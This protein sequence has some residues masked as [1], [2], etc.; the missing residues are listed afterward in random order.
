MFYSQVILAK[1]GPL[2]KVWLAA[3]WGDK[4]LARPQIFAT[5]IAQSVDTIVHPTAPLALRMSGY[6]LLGV[7]RIYSRKVKYV[8]NDCTEA[9]WKLQMAFRSGGSGAAKELLEEAQLGAAVHGAHTVEY[10]ELP[11]VQGFCLPL[12][13]QNEWI[14]DDQDDEPGHEGHAGRDTDDQALL[15][16]PSASTPSGHGRPSSLSMSDS[17][18]A[19][20]QEEAWV[21]FDPDQ[22]DPDVPLDDSRVSEVE[23]VRAAG[24]S[25]SIDELNVSHA[26][27]TDAAAALKQQQ[28]QQ[29]QD[30]HEDSMDLPMLDNDDESAPGLADLP[31]QDT[32]LQLSTVS[33][34]PNRLSISALEDDESHATAEQPK[35]TS[36]PPKHARRKRRKVLIDNQNTELSNAHIKL[37]L[38]DTSDICQRQVHPA[39]QPREEGTAPPALTS[40][41]Q[42]PLSLTRPFLAPLHS[43]L[44]EL[45]QGAWYLALGQPPS[46]ERDT[47]LPATEQ[48]RQAPTGA[49]DDEDDASISRLSQSSPAP[50][51]VR[52]DDEESLPPVLLEREED[53]EDFPGVQLQDEE[54]SLQGASM[55]MDDE[56]QVSL[57]LDDDD[58]D[59]NDASVD[60]LAN[61][62]AY[63]L[64]PRLQQRL[65][66]IRENEDDATD[67]DNDDK[68][69]SLDWQELVPTQTSRHKAAMCFMECLQLQT[70]DFVHLEQETPYG[71]IRLMAGPKLNEEPP[72]ANWA[73]VAAQEG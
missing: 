1:K 3:H 48:V 72:R 31:E 36:P 71:A 66:P 2:A 9:M 51:V 53:D 23:M 34:Q 58:D 61:R 56:D 8:L 57:P 24:D 28:Q 6:L 12:P 29:Q 50:P 63:Q 15:L 26:T 70:W 44:Q 5:D 59:E 35:R 38:A 41:E 39:A 46:F 19:P 30:P 40:K 17:P 52:D 37:M 33:D 42:D 18:Y 45:W 11:I 21:P 49:D 60:P 64:L 73:E 32:S 62:P 22:E 27:D 55:N 13:D 54:P 67:D 69:E 7:V 4:K 47:P 68:V 20:P 16:L 25:F 43:D 14:L 65:Q 10:E